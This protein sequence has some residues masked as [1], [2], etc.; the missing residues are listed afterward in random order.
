MIF[1]IVFCVVKFCKK[2][3]MTMKDINRLCDELY[4]N[5]QIDGI[6][7][8]TFKLMYALY[9]GGS[10]VPGRATLSSMAA[11]DAVESWMSMDNLEDAGDP[12]QAIINE[13]RSKFHSVQES[14]IGKDDGALRLLVVNGTY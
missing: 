14:L 3:V 1:P 7:G 9:Q 6:S 5:G 8:E 4:K 13:M 2:A 11:C 12:V 10:E